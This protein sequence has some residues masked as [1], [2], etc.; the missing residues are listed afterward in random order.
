MRQRKIK[1]FETL[2]IWVLLFYLVVNI[3]FVVKLYGMLNLFWKNIG[4]SAPLNIVY[5]TL[6]NYS[7]ELFSFHEIVTIYRIVLIS[8]IFIILS[9]TL[10]RIVTNQFKNIFKF[11]QIVLLSIVFISILLQKIF[12][13][14]GKTL[15]QILKM[16][17]INSDLFFKNLQLLVNIRYLILVIFIILFLLIIIGLI[18][19]LYEIIIQTDRVNLLLVNII[20]LLA[21]FIFSIITYNHIKQ[22]EKYDTLNRVYV[23]KGLLTEYSLEKGQIKS[24]TK[25]HIKPINYEI[26]NQEARELLDGQDIYNVDTETLERLGYRLIIASR[27][28]NE[29]VS[30]LTDYS[31]LNL[32]STYDFINKFDRRY[33]KNTK[34]LQDKFYTS[35]NKL[36]Y[37]YSISN[38]ILKYA[39]NEDLNINEKS[40]VIIEIKNV[41]VNSK[42]NTIYYNLENEIKYVDDLNKYI[43][44]NNLKEL[45]S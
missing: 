2:I 21:A 20:F 16:S 37:I 7:Y 5:H 27:V 28:K 29:N 6:V 33:I 42:G 23:K 24:S 1:T 41:F 19:T 22:V 34:D 18:I 12:F 30:Y 15:T 39:I 11:N 35:N 9:L 13:L 17:D 31:K 43:N 36:V 14:V 44:E 8:L 4:F 38:E 10:Y 45:G 26:L 3:G 32:N 40:Y 25:L